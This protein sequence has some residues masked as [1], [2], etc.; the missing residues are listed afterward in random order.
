[1][2]A[3]SDANSSLYKEFRRK[4]VYFIIIVVDNSTW[5][6][7]FIGTHHNEFIYSP[8][9]RQALLIAHS[10]Q[11]SRCSPNHPSSPSFMP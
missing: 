3:S 6:K 9:M 4:P 5:Q 7:H 10:P 1:M 11:Q 2:L 8:K